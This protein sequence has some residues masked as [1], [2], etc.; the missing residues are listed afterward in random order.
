MLRSALAAGGLTAAAAGLAPP[1]AAASTTA[2]LDWV[3][4]TGYGADPSG[5]AD[6]TGAI[7]AALAATPVGG[8]CYLP[9]GTYTTSAPIVVPPTVTLLGSHG[10]HLDITTCAIKPSAGFTGLA[11][12]ATT[13]SGTSYPA[14]T[15]AAVIVLLDQVAGSYAQPSREQRLANLS[16][17][18]S[19]LPAGSGVNGIEAVGWVHGVCLDNI[20][21][22]KA[23]GHGVNGLARDGGNAY[24]WRMTRIAVSAAGTFGYNVA[25]FTDSTFVDCEAIGTGGS[26]WY[27]GAD[28]NGH[29][30][31][32][33]AEWAGRYGFEVHSGGVS[34]YTFTA[35]STDRNSMHGMYIV[36]SGGVG[37]IVLT[38]C[39]FDRDG[40]NGGAGGGGFAGLAV[41]GSSSP[42]VV[43]GCITAVHGDDGG[44]GVQSPQYG[45]SVTNAKY[46]AVDGG[47]YWGMTAGWHDG[48]GNMT[49]RRGPNIGEAT[50]PQTA[51]QLVLRD[52]WGTDNGSTMSVA[53]NAADQTGLSI[54][55]T[56]SNVNQPLVL[57][58]AGV[59]A[60]DA[61]MKARVVGDT[62]SRVILSAAGTLS[63]GPGNAAIDTTWGRLGPAQVGSPDS[64]L[65]AGLAGKGLRVKEGG[66]AKMGTVVLNGATAVT[67][68]TT[69]VTAASRIFLTVQAP[70]GT[71]TGV[72]YVAGRTAGTSFTVKGQAGD[73][74]TVAWL[75]VEPA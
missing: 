28:G 66:N 49:L 24:S 36:D 69:A 13:V 41:S 43:N 70:G 39:M 45:L 1:A 72:A 71:P 68:A 26:G 56:A 17:D 20:G 53:L 63:L 4:V 64:D 54:V 19:N 16:L 65:V 62:S 7:N 3:E 27:I 31:N 44:S 73:T 30:T 2:S 52:P 23:P 9:A 12:P 10:T 55:A 35:C 38:G 32:C 22:Y 34:S 57:L 5:A 29:F 74:S 75:I 47:F 40:R 37:P 21:I 33:R 60:A 18:C 46:V 50:G 58:T 6:S 42:I 59:S 15:I 48:G 14:T 11:L 61:L 67:V 8:V 25:N 51:P